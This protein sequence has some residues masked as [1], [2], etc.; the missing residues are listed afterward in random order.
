VPILLGVILG[1]ALTIA[2]AF[3]Y[4]KT[5]GRAGN[6]LPPS[7]AGGNPPMVNWDVVDDRWQGVRTDLEKLGTDVQ[8]G[9]HRLTQSKE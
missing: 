7:A 2:G 4:D 1:I 8:N 9:W 3:V 5:T 6:G